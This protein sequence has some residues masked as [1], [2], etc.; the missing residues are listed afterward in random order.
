MVNDALVLTGALTKG[1]AGTWT[2]DLLDAG[3]PLVPTGYTLMTFGSTTFK[4]V[5]FHLVDGPGLTGGSLAIVG[6]RLVISGV[7]DPPS[8]QSQNSPSSSSD[9]TGSASNFAT[10]SVPDSAAANVTPTP[11]PGCAAL[12]TLGVGTLLGWRRRRRE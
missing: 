11:E 7:E 2:I 8:Q 5:D 1:S 10:G 12:L 3:A 6:N 4:S 9:P